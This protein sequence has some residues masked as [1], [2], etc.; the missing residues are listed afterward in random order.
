[1]ALV[2]LVF[3]H[4]S[5][6][7]LVFFVG[8]FVASWQLTKRFQSGDYALNL[9]PVPR[10]KRLAG[11]LIAQGFVLGSLWIMDLI[12]LGMQLFIP[13]G[14]LALPLTWKAVGISLCAT[15]AFVA[16]SSVSYTHLDVYKRQSLRKLSTRCC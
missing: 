3:L 14:S 4:G 5:Y 13:F 9:I 15:L 10:K 7:N 11:Q 6:V 1:M 8:D 2:F 12:I 16:Y